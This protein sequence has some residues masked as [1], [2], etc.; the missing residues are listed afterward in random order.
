LPSPGGA[1]TLPARTPSNEARLA[2][3]PWQKRGTVLPY[4][5]KIS[6]FV[7]VFKPHKK[8]PMSEPPNPNQQDA[9]AEKSGA[10]DQARQTYASV[11]NFLTIREDDGVPLMLF[12]IL[13]RIL[14]IIL[15]ILMSPFILLGL[16][17]AFLA[18]F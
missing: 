17:V 7:L 3:A 12:K 1:D 13:L 10:L 2:I 4:P 18:A 15:L 16:F 6:T 11:D 5:K 14:G 9:E 8:D